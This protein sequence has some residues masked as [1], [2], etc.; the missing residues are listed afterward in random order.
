MEREVLAGDEPTAR[1]AGP[2][3]KRL[4]DMVWAICNSP[5]FVFVP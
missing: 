4:E 3:R 2:W 1:L 5:E